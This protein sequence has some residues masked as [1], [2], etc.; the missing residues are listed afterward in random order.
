MKR[1]KSMLSIVGVLMLSFS[2]VSG[3]SASNL[4][5]PPVYTCGDVSANCGGGGYKPPI[6]CTVAP[7]PLPT[8][9]IL[10]VE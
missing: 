9:I 5:G 1:K 6:K 7:C 2:V 3:A 8:S 4:M 10:E